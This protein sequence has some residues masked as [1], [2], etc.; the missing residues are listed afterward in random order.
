MK[1][2]GLFDDE[3]EAIKKPW[4]PLPE[5]ERAHAKAKPKKP[6]AKK[7]IPVMAA[8]YFR[9][10]TGKP[11]AEYNSNP[12]K[13]SPVYGAL[14]S[15]MHRFGINTAERIAMFLALVTEHSRD[16]QEPMI[17][18]HHIGNAHLIGYTSSEIADIAHDK[19]VQILLL[20]A[21]WKARDINVQADQGG[22]VQAAGQ[23]YQGF[24]RFGSAHVR[25]ARLLTAIR[26]MEKCHD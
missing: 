3:V 15:A 26:E 23:L 24:N 14:E 7:P 10:L 18:P 25:Y 13:T 11:E 6:Q 20:A 4:E 17:Q 8:D 21:F 16:F 5:A 22:L 2:G 9:I 19:H 12:N 1:P